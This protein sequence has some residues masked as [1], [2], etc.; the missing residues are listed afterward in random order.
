M[1]EAR[2]RG[3]VTAGSSSWRAGGAAEEEKSIAVPC[4][5][6]ASGEG[7]AMAIGREE[8]RCKRSSIMMMMMMMI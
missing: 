3:R 2:A 4:S 5:S 7:C 6:I 1:A 8:E